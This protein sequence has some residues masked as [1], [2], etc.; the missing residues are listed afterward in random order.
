MKKSVVSILLCVFLLTGCGL[1]P[2][3]TD[4][5]FSDTAKQHTNGQNSGIFGG[6]RGD[7]S[8]S[9]NRSTGV[10]LHDKAPD[11]KKVSIDEYLA[12][13]EASEDFTVMSD[14][15]DPR[16]PFQQQ[17]AK[18]K[19]ARGKNFADY[20]NEQA[21]LLDYFERLVDKNVEAYN[22]DK[23]LLSSIYLYMMPF[24]SMELAMGA[25]F[26]EEMDWALV[27]KGMIL[28]VETFGGTDVTV[29]RKGPHNYTVAYTDGGGKRVEDSFRANSRG[30][31]MLSYVDGKLDGFFEYLALDDGTGVWQNNRER[32]VLRCQDKTV[33]A[34]YY[35]KLSEDAKYYDETDLLLDSEFSP[36][37][38]WV[39]DCDEFHTQITFD[40]ETMNVMTTNFFF[41][42][43]ANAE[44]YPVIQ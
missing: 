23:G 42:S 30:I 38:D 14:F 16:D 34:C 3:V 20:Y 32:L 5:T 7:P 39:A 13:F 18:E 35:S 21:V 4:D 43:I 27:K 12:Y 9:I 15:Y 2:A 6:N 10:D 37:A 41:G 1:L 19:E 40:G 26:T 31:Q 33:L 24:S 11:L 25:S 29:E 22:E 36:D 44:I 28:A 8:P 17:Q